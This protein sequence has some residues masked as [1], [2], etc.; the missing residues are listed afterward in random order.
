MPLGVQGQL[1][2]AKKIGMKVYMLFTN[3]ELYIDNDYFSC[4][5]TPGLDEKP[6]SSDSLLRSVIERRAD[7]LHSQ[8]YRLLITSRPCNT[9]YD[10]LRQPGESRLT[11]HLT[12]FSREARNGFMRGYVQQRHKE[13]W[14]AVEKK[15]DKLLT[16]ASSFIEPLTRLPLVATLLAELLPT[17]NIKEVPKSRWELFNILLLGGLLRRDFPDADAEVVTNDFRQLPP[18]RQKALLLLSDLALQGLLATPPM[19]VF[20]YTDI[21]E[22]GKGQSKA[23]REELLEVAKSV[24]VSFCETD[25]LQE[26]TYYH[27][28]HL[29]F[30]EFLAAMSL[31]HSVHMN[32]EVNGFSRLA[33]SAKTLTIGERFEN[34]WLFAVGFFKT[35]P[36]VFF[37]ALF[38]NV[39]IDMRTVHREQLAMQNMLFKMLQEM[40]PDINNS[41]REEYSSALESIAVYLNRIVANSETSNLEDTSHLE[42]AFAGPSIDVGI[43]CHALRLL[44]GLV[45]VKWNIEWATA[46]YN[47][48]D[49]LQTQYNLQTLVISSHRYRSQPYQELERFDREAK[50][51]ASLLQTTSLVNLQLQRVPFKE[52]ELQV[53][54]GGLS[55]MNHSLKHLSLWGDRKH[56]KYALAMEVL[57]SALGKHHKRLSWLEINNINLY[58]DSAMQPLVALLD[59]SI[60]LK[61]LVVRGCPMSNTAFEL[62]CSAV[63]RSR[64]LTFLTVIL[65]ETFEYSVPRTEEERKES[66]AHIEQQSEVEKLRASL[67]RVVCELKQL[68]KDDPNQ[69]KYYFSFSNGPRTIPETGELHQAVEHYQLNLTIYERSHSPGQRTDVYTGVIRKLL[70]NWSGLQR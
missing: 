40:I 66:S 17:M 43:L 38:S 23:V 20:R 2:K 54:A 27:F 24:M 4:F 49:A 63:K 26:V 13:S 7:G 6:L 34:F 56:Q 19:L 3:R 69:L 31:R 59:S 30:Q 46:F 61:R 15:M 29:S 33:S 11:Y 18:E 8:G 32:D 21:V 48:L 35:K 70:P 9:V 47:V 50:S 10:L 60:N 42:G 57:C 1:A 12:G 5:H 68:Y 62:L 16:H 14:G 37:R 67:R 58:N 25:E 64:S 45:T 51:L 41:I 55:R 39:N 44:P 52:E 28:L 65:R 22:K 53:L 36:E